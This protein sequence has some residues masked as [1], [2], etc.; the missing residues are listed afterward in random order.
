MQ[1]A[2][3]KNTTCDKYNTCKRTQ[4]DYV[5]INYRAICDKENDY[6]WYIENESKVKNDSDNE[7]N[8]EN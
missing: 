8:Q 6:I 1:F 2:L 7:N 5:E 3:C 4:T